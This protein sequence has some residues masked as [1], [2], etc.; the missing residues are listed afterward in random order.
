MKLSYFSL[1]VYFLLSLTACE[2]ADQEPILRTTNIAYYVQSTVKPPANSECRLI[3]NGVVEQVSVFDSHS[4]F[5]S[6]NVSGGDSLSIEVDEALNGY[7]FNI[8]LNYNHCC[9]NVTDKDQKVIV[10]TD[11]EKNPDTDVLFKF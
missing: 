3:R 2:D 9:D 8:T 1:V 4:V 11:I 10:H 6:V 7:K 5:G